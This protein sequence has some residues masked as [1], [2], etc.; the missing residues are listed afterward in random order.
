MRLGDVPVHGEVPRGPRDPDADAINVFAGNHLT[1]Q[2]GGLG[3]AEGE[4]QHVVLVVGG[5]WQFGEERRIL[6]D[7]VAGGAGQGALARALEV[8]VVGVRRLEQVR[9]ERH[10]HRLGG[11]VLVVVVGDGDS[12]FVFFLEFL[13]WGGGGG[14]E[15]RRER[16]R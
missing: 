4:V 14:G 12:V 16:E 9:S 11:A 10:S 7:D 6:D 13:K 15:E 3:E 1:S 5:L 8:D 2:P